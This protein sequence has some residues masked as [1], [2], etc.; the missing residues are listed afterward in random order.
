MSMQFT[1][2]GIQFLIGNSL[3]WLA[4]MFEFFRI[5]TA[6]AVM[7]SAGTAFCLFGGLMLRRWLSVTGDW[8]AV[9]VTALVAFIVLNTVGQG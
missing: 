7:I 4:V 8:I 6:A 5:G 3:L 9:G 1:Q 2:R